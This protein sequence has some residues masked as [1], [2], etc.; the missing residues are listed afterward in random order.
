MGD[1]EAGFLRSASDSRG[2]SDE[3]LERERLLGFIQ[4]VSPKRKRTLHRGGEVFKEGD[5]VD[6]FYILTD[7]RLGVYQEGTSVGNIECGE[8]FGEMSLL[9]GQRLR[10]KTV[11]CESE[12]C[13]V[14][15][16]RWADFERLV[17]KSRVVRKSMEELARKRQQRN[18]QDECL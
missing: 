8:C 4:L 18:E 5:V 10:T 3:E 7:G 9:T 1:F 13:A 16:I 11:T 14:V 6:R 15:S 12:S 2:R 17:Q